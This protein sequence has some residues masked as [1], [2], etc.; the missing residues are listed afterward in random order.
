[1]FNTIVLLVLILSSTEHVTAKPLVWKGDVVVGDWEEPLGVGCSA[2]IE[3]K[4]K[5]S[6]PIQTS[7]VAGF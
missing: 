7:S 5:C 3:V 4:L 1:M 6:I 2:A